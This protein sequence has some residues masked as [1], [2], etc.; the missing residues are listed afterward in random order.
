MKIH[1]IDSVELNN[2]IVILEGK[3]KDFIDQSRYESAKGVDIAIMVINAFNESL[4][5]VDV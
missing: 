2:Q 5:E 1:G 4:T 3:R